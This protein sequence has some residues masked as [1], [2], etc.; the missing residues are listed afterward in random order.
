MSGLLSFVNTTDGWNYLMNKEW[1]SDV[2][3]ANKLYKGVAGK[4]VWSL[5]INYYQLLVFPKYSITRS[6]CRYLLTDAYQELL[7]PSED[8][9]SLKETENVFKTV[10]AITRRANRYLVEDMKVLSGCGQ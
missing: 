10:L 1:L 6:Y 2:Q 8:T 7:T 4:W 5:S 3:S 9:P